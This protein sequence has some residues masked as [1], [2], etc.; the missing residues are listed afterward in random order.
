M[1]KSSHFQKLVWQEIEKK[2]HNKYLF[3]KALD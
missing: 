1:K 2:Y 3:S